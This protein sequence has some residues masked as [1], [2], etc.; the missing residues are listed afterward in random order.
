MS[1]QPPEQFPEEPQDIDAALQAHLAEGAEQ[2]REF[3]TED[4]AFEME[5]TLH[6]NRILGVLRANGLVPEEIHL[7]D[8]PDETEIQRLA[9]DMP[10]S[11]EVYLFAER[12]IM[13]LDAVGQIEVEEDSVYR[14][15]GNEPDQESRD[16][17]LEHW[18]GAIASTTTE[19]PD[20]WAWLG[21]MKSLFGDLPLPKD[22]G[23]RAAKVDMLVDLYIARRDREEGTRDLEQEVRE[24]VR[25]ILQA[26]HGE[27]DEI[28]TM[29]DA[30]LGLANDRQR[31]KRTPTIQQQLDRET[32]ARLETLKTRIG[33]SQEE[34]DELIAQARERLSEDRPQ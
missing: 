9:E 15:S 11:E 31:K 2:S 5:Q 13:L 17:I 23:E 28:I 10:E 33:V 18:I 14:M 8:A 27:H 4:T 24:D 32:L 16:R 25:A 21:A 30:I 7:S 26:G 19:K 34:I 6:L 20:E 3:E 29:T 22:P 1:G 12:T